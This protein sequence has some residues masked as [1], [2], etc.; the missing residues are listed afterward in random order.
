MPNKTAHSAAELLQYIAPEGNATDT[1]ISNFIENQTQGRSLPLSVKVF[2]GIGAIISSLCF[3]LFLSATGMIHF[4]SPLNLTLWGIAFVFG[5][6]GLYMTINQ[7]QTLKAHFLLQ[8]SLALMAAGK[9]MFAFGLDQTI[10]SGWGISLGLFFMT[11]LTY[12]LYPLTIDRF[13]SSFALLVSVLINIGWDYTLTPIQGW[14]LSGLFCVQFAGATF[15]LTRNNLKHTYI[16]LFYAF[17]LALCVNV[18]FLTSSIETNWVTSTNAVPLYIINLVLTGGLIFLLGWLF[19]GI[20]AL[21][22]PPLSFAVF[23]GLCLGTFSA[24]GILAAIIL[25]ILGYAKHAKPLTVAGILMLPFFLARYYYDLNVILLYKSGI[26]AGSG[27]IL[28]GARFYLQRFF[29][30]R[31]KEAFPNIPPEVDG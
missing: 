27:L 30:R 8:T 25:L 2:A 18:L 22:K 26:L 11:L 13:F 23:G 10:S 7:A 15:L 19:G 1:K 20:N 5:A 17:I 3:V 24:P 14:L 21:K 4:F 16:P 28:L 29:L 9:L 12:P 31:E 6:L